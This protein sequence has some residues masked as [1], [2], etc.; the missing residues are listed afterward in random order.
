MSQQN[1]R[2]VAKLLRQQAALAAFGSFAFREPDLLRILTEAAR[3]C[4]ESLGVPFAKVCRYR[5]G[6]DDLLIEAGWGW[7]SGVVGLIV[8]QADESSPQGR[9]YVTGSPVI[10]RNI[11][12]AN[13]LSL[14]A[15]YEEHAVVS[16]VDVV[17]PAIDGMAY[18]VLEIDSTQQHQYDEHDINFLTGFANVLAEAVATAMR[19]KALREALAAKDLMAEELQH[20]VRNNLQTVSAMLT[21]YARTTT[22]GT[23]RDGVDRIVRRVTTLGQVYDTLLGVGLSDTIDLGLYLRTLC[24]ALPGTL[25][26]REQPVELVC[27]V[28]TV[29]ASL[30]QAASFGLAVAEMVANSYD[31]AFPDR[32]GTITVTLVRSSTDSAMLTVADN[33]VGLNIDPNSQRHGVGL[34]RRL[35]ER[36]GGVLMLHQ[37]GGARWSIAFTTEPR[38]SISSAA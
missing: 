29:P 38:A 23:A 26:E 34:V 33:G 11:N 4:A 31:H 28:E 25:D 37:D 35:V 9:A 32:S 19:V 7:R 5:P 22:P 27:S 30:D 2:T 1:E 17:I 20:R 12:T 14:P 10:I 8:S 3:I 36:G 16:T 24:D 18:G 21:T 15:F 6:H 13:D